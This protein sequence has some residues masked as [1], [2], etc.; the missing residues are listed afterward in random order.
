MLNEESRCEFRMSMHNERGGYLFVVA[1][2]KHERQHFH[3]G[4]A[5]VGFVGRKSDVN[6]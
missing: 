1:A 6:T 4:Q 3:C 2:G 5:G